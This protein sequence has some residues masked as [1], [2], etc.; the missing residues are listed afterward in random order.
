[1]NSKCI[2]AQCADDL[3]LEVVETYRS[4]ILQTA[5]AITKNFHDAE[6]VCQEVLLR[7]ARNIHAF[8]RRSTL[9]TWLFTIVRNTA[10]NSIRRRVSHPEVSI[11]DFSPESF[12]D[13][14]PSEPAARLDLSQKFDS[15]TRV[16]N[17]RER[18]AFVLR[19]YDG[20]S[21]AQIARSLSTSSENAK[22]I[23][24]RAT[25]KFRRRLG[26]DKDKLALIRIGV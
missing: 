17:E 4:F 21:F 22:L 13:C 16:L 24:W 1:M 5:L 10:F 3:L 8:Q 9:K 23:V 26:E 6:D 18:N 19:H 11:E 15:A 2:T 20:Y 25:R 12:V 7:V 14:G